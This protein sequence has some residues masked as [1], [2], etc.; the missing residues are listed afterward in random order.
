MLHA[1]PTPSGLPLLQ[2]KSLEIRG[3]ACDRTFTFK[4]LALGLALPIFR[5]VAQ[6]F[7]LGFG[8]VRR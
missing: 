2:L 8:H 1:T 6:E 5:L 7:R 4:V 3:L